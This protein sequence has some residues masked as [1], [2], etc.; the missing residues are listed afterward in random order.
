MSALVKKDGYCTKHI[1][2]EVNTMFNFEGTDFCG[3]LKTIP[4]TELAD[5]RPAQTI[6]FAGE[7]S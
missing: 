1:S 2:S 4:T 5:D 6:V 7:E 3:I